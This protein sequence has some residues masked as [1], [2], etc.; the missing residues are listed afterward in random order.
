MIKL[1]W[2]IGTLVGFVTCAH[3]RD[4]KA[5]LEVPMSQHSG[6]IVQLYKNGIEDRDLGGTARLPHN[7]LVQS[8]GHHAL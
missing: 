1:S 7:Q 8:W 6:L 2:D 5:R 4:D 3:A